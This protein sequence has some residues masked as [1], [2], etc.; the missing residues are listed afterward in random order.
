MFP[1][2]SATK[3]LII[4]ALPL[5]VAVSCE[6]QDNHE[7]SG[8]SGKAEYVHQ[9]PDGFPAP[10]I[11]SD[12]ALTHERILLGEM[13]FYEPALSRDSSLSC[14]SCHHPELA[15]TDGLKVSVGFHGLPGTRNAQGLTNVAYETEFFRDGGSH[16]L[17]MQIQGP[18]EAEN[19][20][21]FSMAEMAARLQ[22]SERYQKLAQQAYGRPLDMFVIT[23][24][25]AAYERSLVSGNSAWDMYQRGNNNAITPSQ[26]R[27]ADLFFSDRLNCTACHSGFNFSNS[28]YANIGL[29]RE[30]PDTG[31]ARITGKPEDSGKFRVP[32]LRNVALTAPYMHDGSMKTLEDVVRFYETGGHPHRNLD[33]DI[34]PFSL[35][36]EERSDVIHFLESLTDTAF[37]GY[38]TRRK[39]VYQ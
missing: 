34:A 27:G 25:I 9:W 28:I 5:L 11:P 10:A 12:N 23:R 17:E 13:L 4:A 20:M 32:S 15:F 38:H 6:Q 24:S 18:V 39:K 22:S 36:D 2:Y 8:E 30:Y 26:K 35:S 33:P 37:V 7:P 1:A 19:E 29:Y 16:T 3:R 14:E 21:N 31:R